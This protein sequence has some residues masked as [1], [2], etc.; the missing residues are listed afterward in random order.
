MVFFKSISVSLTASSMRGS[1]NA[2]RN[3]VMKTYFWIRFLRMCMH[4][5]L[6]CVIL[7]LTV[8]LYQL[9]IMNFCQIKFSQ[10][11][12]RQIRL[13]YHR[14]RWKQQTVSSKNWIF[15]NIWCWKRKVKMDLTSRAAI[16]MLW[17]C[18]QA[19]YKRS[20]KVV[21]EKTVEKKLNQKTT[22]QKIKISF[23][24]SYHRARRFC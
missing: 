13:H 24:N 9:A 11:R 17:L 4:V 7:S 6:I 20:M 10:S 21:S 3:E 16:W 14:P 5:W 1:L 12:H 23:F 8:W 19:K 15:P 22:K 18:M 2:H